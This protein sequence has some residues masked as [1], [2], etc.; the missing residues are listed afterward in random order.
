MRLEYERSSSLDSV[1]RQSLLVD[2]CD[3]VSTHF[4]LTDGNVH[5]FRIGGKKLKCVCPRD[6]I[7]H[8]NRVGGRGG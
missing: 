4:R 5:S 3:S 2:D 8:F 6:C 1:G 7:R